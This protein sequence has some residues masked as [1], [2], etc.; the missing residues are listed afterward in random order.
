MALEVDWRNEYARRLIAEN[1]NDLQRVLNGFVAEHGTSRRA[2]LQGKGARSS[3]VARSFHWISEVGVIEPAE[4]DKVTEFL[5]IDATPET[6]RFIKCVASEGTI[7][8]GLV[9]WLREMD[10]VAG[11]TPIREQLAKVVRNR[12]R[13]RHRGATLDKLRDQIVLFESFDA[14]RSKLDGARQI[15]RYLPGVTIAEIGQALEQ[16]KPVDLRRHLALLLQDCRGKGLSTKDIVFALRSTVPSDRRPLSLLER[17]IELAMPSPTCPPG[18]AA[19]LGADSVE[20]A[21]SEL[22]K[23]REQLHEHLRPFEIPGADAVVEMKLWGIRRDDLDISYKEVARAVWQPQQG[24]LS[25]EGVS[26]DSI[27]EQARNKGLTKARDALRELAF[28]R[29]SVLPWQLAEIAVQGL[30]GRDKAFSE[31]GGFRLGAAAQFISRTVVPMPKQ[32]LRTVALAELPFSEEMRFGWSDSYARFLKS[33]QTAPLGRILL[34]QIVATDFDSPSRQ[35]VSGSR[36][37]MDSVV[38][39]F[40]K[41]AGLSA[42]TYRRALHSACMGMPVKDE[43]I[44]ALGEALGY[45]RNSPAIVLLKRL[46]GEADLEAAL[47]SWCDGLLSRKGAID[48]FLRVGELYARERQAASDRL[49]RG[50]Y[51]LRDSLAENLQAARSSPS[52]LP[53]D[54]MKARAQ[55]IGISADEHFNV[56]KR[57]HSEL[58]EREKEDNSKIAKVEKR[59]PWRKDPMLYRLP[60]DIRWDAI[61]ER[62]SSNQ[63]VTV[64]DLLDLLPQ[65]FAI[66]TEIESRVGEATPWLVASAAFYKQPDDALIELRNQLRLNKEAVGTPQEFLREHAEWVRSRRDLGK[67]SSISMRMKFRDPF[68]APGSRESKPKEPP[69]PGMSEET[70]SA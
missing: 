41:R 18:V 3:D 39:A 56:F 35:E 14:S 60:I 31:K 23:L 42:I 51:S 37:L 50:A 43:H 10:E 61:A 68:V 44:E 66:I 12:E 26:V 1:Q 5:G 33:K 47:F 69:P 67:L 20:A 54:I 28:R 59:E 48:P 62:L 52:A 11:D 49:A 64:Q 58:L 7:V 27:V 46:S 57:V 24:E 16:E 22:S 40:L 6:K 2:L 55:F 17:G 70:L 8:D 29:T 36:T 15:L 30:N 25:K 19:Y 21:E 63:W 13:P 9:A 65:Y 53:E 34:C 38:S 32:L 4:L 45:R